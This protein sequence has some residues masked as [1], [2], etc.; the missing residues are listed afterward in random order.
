M[1]LTRDPWIYLN[2]ASV[3]P[4]LPHVRAA[5]EGLLDLQQRGGTVHYREI[6]ARVEV[7][8]ALAAELLGAPT[9]NVF[10]PRNTTTGINVAALSLPL[11]AEGGV[12][13]P[14]DEFPANVRPWLSREGAPV[15]WLRMVDGRFAARDVEMALE[16][17]HAEAL[18]VSHVQYMSGFRADLDAL[19]QAC[20][21]HDAWFVVDAVQG[22]GLWPVDVKTCRPDVLSASSHKALLGVEGIGVGYV[23]DRVLDELA[24]PW[25]GWLS[26]ERPWAFDEHTQ[27]YADSA[28]RYEEGTPNLIGLF[29]LGAALERVLSKGPRVIEA[30]L[31]GLVD[32]LI[33]GIDRLGL[34]LRSPRQPEARSHIVSFVPPRPG[35]A[36]QL[37]SRGVVVAERGGAVRVAPCDLNTLEEIDRFLRIL[38]GTLSVDDG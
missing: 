22:L 24:V 29:A 21:D 11:T 30:E 35:L 25:G 15:H 5:V 12:L 38:E 7:V 13:L 33:E 17:S 28:R 6:F 27:A 34:P 14:E 10:F 16:A 37:E 32:R 1:S 18:S 19:G 31:Q 3:S 8:R 4:M 2:F 26:L 9:R 20:R 23:S 36:E